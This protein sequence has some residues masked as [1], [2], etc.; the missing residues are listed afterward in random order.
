MKQNKGSRKQ[1]KKERKKNTQGVKLLRVYLPACLHKINLFCLFKGG[2][3][4]DNGLRMH[5]KSASQC[6]FALGHF[7]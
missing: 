2:L 7:I 5:F 1:K 6:K 3:F 4:I